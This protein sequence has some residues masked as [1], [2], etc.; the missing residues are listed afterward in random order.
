MFACPAAAA[1]PAAAASGAVNLDAVDVGPYA[2]LV[3]DVNSGVRV[4]ARPL[5]SLHLA[6]ARRQPSASTSNMAFT[7]HVVVEQLLPANSNA[8]ADTFSADLCAE[9]A[10]RVE[11][12]AA[13]WV[14]Y[15]A[16][17]ANAPLPVLPP[18]STPASDTDASASASAASASASAASASAAAA[19][20]SDALYRKLMDTL[21][22]EAVSVPLALHCLLEQVEFNA[23]LRYSTHSRE[24]RPDAR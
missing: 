23:E 17:L 14:D 13:E 22:D 11:A 1:K 19:P 21:P 2:A 9:L 12:R 18:A 24:R 16:W 6:A 5:A 20:P 8:G 3:F 10:P 7:H 15:E 4:A